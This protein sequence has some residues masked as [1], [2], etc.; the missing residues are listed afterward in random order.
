MLNIEARSYYSGKKEGIVQIVE[1][2]LP[3]L[4]YPSLGY[5]LLSI[6]GRNPAIGRRD[7]IEWIL[8]YCKPELV[9]KEN[10]DICNPR[11]PSLHSGQV[12]TLINQLIIAENGVY[13]Y[14]GPGVSLQKAAS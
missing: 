14:L 9:V 4:P 6:G 1:E 10:I 2:L 12:C 13:V 8:E 5:A 7:A 11:L 3:L